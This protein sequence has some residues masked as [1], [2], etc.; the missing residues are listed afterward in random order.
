VVVPLPRQPQGEGITVLRR[1]LVVDSERAG[2]AVYRVP[3]PASLLRPP[4]PPPSTPVP[5]PS[6]EPSPV[7]L[8]DRD[9][10]S[11]PVWVLIAA[12][13]A[14]AVAAIAGVSSLRRRD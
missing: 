9:G 5:T 7:S 11:I 3:L 8:G 6:T 13:A 10:S 2:S 1:G 12:I 14:M 4:S